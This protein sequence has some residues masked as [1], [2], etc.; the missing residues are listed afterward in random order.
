[1]VI[2]PPLSGVYSTAILIWVAEID[3][4]LGDSHKGFMYHLCIIYVFICFMVAPR[5][6]KRDQGPILLTAVYAQ[7]DRL[8]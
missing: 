3:P 6:S 1:M 8:F 4:K 2:Q 7:Y 5:G